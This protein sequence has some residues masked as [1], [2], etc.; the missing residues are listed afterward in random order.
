V[1]FDQAPRK[2][3]LR[4][5]GKE[6]RALTGCEGRRDQRRSRKAWGDPE[7]AEI[8][9]LNPCVRGIEAG[10]RP[11]RLVFAER[12]APERQLELA[13]GRSGPGGRRTRTEAEPR[14]QRT[15]SLR[16]FGRVEPAHRARA[17]RTSIEVCAEHVLEQPSP[18][19]SSRRLVV[20]LFERELELIIW[21]RR[22]GGGGRNPA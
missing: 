14:E 9:A 6:G 17:T 1:G 10:A 7:P 11:Q 5:A 4:K 15:R 21:R 3:E 13:K 19:L 16:R 18:A 22:R 8:S 12:L 20:A 2:I